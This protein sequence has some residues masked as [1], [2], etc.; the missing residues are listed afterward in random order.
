MGTEGNWESDA[1]NW[2]AWARSPGH[3]SYWYYRDEFF[4]QLVPPPGRFTLDIACGEGRV[5]RDLLARGHRI[6]GVDSSPTLL[7]HA[8]N[9]DPNGMYVQGKAERLPF[10]DGSFDLA[11]AYNCLMDFQDLETAV[12]EAARVLVPAGRLCLSVTHPISDAGSFAGTEP[13]ASFVIEGNYLGAR[14]PFLGTFERNGLVM[15]FRG[16]RYPLEAYFQ[17]LE[18]AGFVIER[19]RE[20]AMPDQALARFGPSS[21]RW[22]RLPLF[23]QMRA[24]RAGSD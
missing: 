10:A 12:R 23:L 17:S 1:E 6:V 2:V 18:Q 15:T 22:R 3:D 20:P 9:A 5:S 4:A 16:W 14:R 21:S 24:K 7:R 13:A 8:R 19:L 11:I